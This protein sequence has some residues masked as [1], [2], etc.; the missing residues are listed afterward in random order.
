MFFGTAVFPGWHLA[1]ASPILGDGYFAE[2]IPIL[3]NIWVWGR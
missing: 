1:A 3:A 2:D